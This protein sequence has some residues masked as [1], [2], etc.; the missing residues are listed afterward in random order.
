MPL[1]LDRDHSIVV[2]LAVEVDEVNGFNLEERERVKRMDHLV[3][4]FRIHQSLLA[5]GAERYYVDA[6]F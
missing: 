1:L 5:A 4:P 2:V 6:S 3:Q